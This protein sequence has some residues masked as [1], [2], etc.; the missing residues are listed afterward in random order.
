MHTPRPEA[1]GLLDAAMAVRGYATVPLKGKSHLLPDPNWN[2]PFDPPPRYRCF[3]ILPDQGGW[4][5]I[6]DELDR[7][8]GTLAAELSRHADV[9]A[10]RGSYER[11]EY[12]VAALAEGK[13]LPDPSENPGLDGAIH[14]IRS[15]ADHVTRFPYDEVCL[16]LRKRM[17]LQFRGYA[18]RS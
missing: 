9:I 16:R 5:T 7:L 11:G 6:V 17:D 4:T 18:R 12:L 15:G 1:L 10:V 8:D 2:S 3:V 13:V 14:V